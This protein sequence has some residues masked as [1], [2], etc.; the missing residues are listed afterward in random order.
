MTDPT[1]PPRSGAVADAAERA[2]ETFTCVTPHKKSKAVYKDEHGFMVCGHCLNSAYASELCDIHGCP[3]AMSNDPTQSPLSGAERVGENFTDDVLRQ[4]PPYENCTY[5]YC[6]LPGQCLS[7]GKCH[8]PR[9]EEVNRR[10]AARNLAQW[11]DRGSLS[12]WT[13]DK[14]GRSYLEFLTDCILEA[15]K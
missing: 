2:G 10:E 13:R 1:Q 15:M 3:L 6:D 8:H 14:T 12:D 9:A 7:E 11:I 5:T 4:M